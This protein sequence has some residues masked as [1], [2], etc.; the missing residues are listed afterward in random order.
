MLVQQFQII[1]FEK[2]LCNLLRLKYPSAVIKESIRISASVTS[3]LSQISPHEPLQFQDLTIPPGVSKN[4]VPNEQYPLDLPR[5]N[6]FPRLIDVSFL[7]DPYWHSIHGTLMNPT[8]FSRPRDFEP[9]RWLNASDKD[10]ERLNRYHVA[11]GRGS[12]MCL[13]LK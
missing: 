9:E 6:C 7:I 11:F 3:R 5:R 8:I 4:P 10:L 13:G 2:L 1:S 12:R